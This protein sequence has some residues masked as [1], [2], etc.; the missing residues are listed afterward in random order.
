LI[1]LI[2]WHFFEAD[3]IYFGPDRSHAGAR[4]GSKGTIQ[5]LDPGLDLVEG[6]RL[7]WSALF[8]EEFDE[9]FRAMP[10]ELRKTIAANT[11]PLEEFGPSLGRPRV[12]TLK[13]VNIPEYEG[14]AFRLD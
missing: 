13:R 11:I 5:G 6:L 14:T 1:A 3:N 9:E 7:S 4:E 8:R 12:D 2:A 10:K